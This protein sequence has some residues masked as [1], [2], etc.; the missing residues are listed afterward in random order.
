MK[1]VFGVLAV[2]AAVISAASA[3]TAATRAVRCGDVQG[4]PWTISIG[5]RTAS[6]D[7]YAVSAAGAACKFARSTAVQVMK[8]N[9]LCKTS[10]CVVSRGT[11]RG[12]T[13]VLERYP[14]PKTKADLG[15]CKQGAT[16]SFSWGPDPTKA[17]R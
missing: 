17:R 6:G 15:A 7:S 3:A 14:L 16:K 1:C 12:W 9:K 11:P 10:T 4:T 8:Q 13:C 5:G 2:L